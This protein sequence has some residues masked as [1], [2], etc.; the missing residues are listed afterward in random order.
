MGRYYS[1]LKSE[2]TLILFSSTPKTE[3]SA[4]YDFWKADEDIISDVFGTYN[5]G[6]NDL[7]YETPKKCTITE[8]IDDDFEDNFEEDDINVDELSK[9]F[10]NVIEDWKIKMEVIIG[11]G[12]KKLRKSHKE[13]KLMMKYLPGDRKV[14]AAKQAIAKDWKIDFQKGFGTTHKKL[15]KLAAEK[16]KEVE[17]V[18]KTDAREPHINKYKKQ[19]VNINLRSNQ[20][21]AYGNLK[22]LI[23]QLDKMINTVQSDISP[24]VH[25][26]PIYSKEARGQVLPAYNN[27]WLDLQ[28]SLLQD[29]N[30][31]SFLDVLEDFKI[32]YNQDKVIKKST[33]SRVEGTNVAMAQKRMLERKMTKKSVTE[34]KHVLK[35]F[36]K[37]GKEHFLIVKKKAENSPDMEDIFS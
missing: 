14:F 26:I 17:G 6:Y 15:E 11:E 20:E 19:V 1:K 37:N 25:S 33:K 10:D 8:I 3:M 22:E 5:Y 30:R 34:S 7:V 16:A 32:K 23:Q 29:G 9:A 21:S 4:S 36:K 31:Q 27:Q 24:T 12:L 18:V 35:Q 28:R 13:R 2:S